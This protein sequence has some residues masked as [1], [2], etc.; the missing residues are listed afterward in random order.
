MPGAGLVPARLAAVPPARLAAVP[1]PRQDALV[2]RRVLGV[3]GQ[4]LGEFDQRV[5]VPGVHRVRRRAEPA[6]DEPVDE[7]PQQDSATRT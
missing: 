3:R 6:H 7:R 4:L 5:G 1:H 2:L